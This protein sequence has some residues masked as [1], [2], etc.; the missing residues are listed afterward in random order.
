MP[1][2]S[3]DR[4]G[5]FTFL[6]LMIVIA[7]IGMLAAIALPSLRNLP[8]RA[9]E[10]TLKTN[11]RTMRDVIDQYYGAHGRYPESLEV[12]VEEGLLRAIP[13]DIMGS[14]DIWQ[15]EYETEGEEDDYG[16]YAEDPPLEPL[17]GEEAP[18]IWDVRS[19]SDG[20]SLL[21]EPYSEW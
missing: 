10:A 19:G 5:G 14:T 1:S 11:L 6:E 3:R 15:L 12:L 13:A 8:R 2:G 7:V 20:L 21:G 18:G 17:P 9:K 4:R 16:Y